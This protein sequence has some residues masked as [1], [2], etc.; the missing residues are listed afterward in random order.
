M[1]GAF[2]TTENK[3][4]PLNKTNIKLRRCLKRGTRISS[5]ISVMI[6]GDGMLKM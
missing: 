2:P 1:H 3:K 4:M 6:F 5:N